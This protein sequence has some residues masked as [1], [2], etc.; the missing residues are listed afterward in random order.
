MPGSLETS[1]TGSADQY[2]PPRLPLWRKTYLWVISI[3]GLIGSSA[4]IAAALAPAGNNHYQPV[5][6]V[7]GFL[8]LGVSGW[9]GWQAHRVELTGGPAQ[10]VRAQLRA[11]SK[12]RRILKRNPGLASELCIG[13]PDLP[14]AFDDGGLVDLNHVPIEVIEQLPGVDSDLAHRITSAR[15]EVGGFDSIDDLEIL[16]DLPPGALPDVRSRL[17]FRKDRP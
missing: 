12:A 8:A 3:G 10:S 2:S 16:L 9:I 13:R 14:R 4:L 1:G 7:L 11:R 5:G 6:G 17:I 15:G